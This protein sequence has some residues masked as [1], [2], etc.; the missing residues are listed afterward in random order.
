MGYSRRRANLILAV[1]ALASFAAATSTTALYASPP[2][3][4]QVTGECSVPPIDTWTNQ[5]TWVWQRVCQGQVADFNAAEDYY[6]KPALFSDWAENRILRPGFLETILLTDP[7]RSALTRQG[8]RV[9][10]AWFVEPVDLENA[11]ISHELWL[12]RSRFESDVFLAQMRTS[13]VLSIRGSSIAGFLSANGSQ[14]ENDVF[15]NGGSEFVEVD[16]VGARVRGTLNLFGSSVFG[17]LDL[18]D[19]HVEDLLMHNDAAFNE[20]DLRGAEIDW[21]LFM[22]GSEFAGTLKMH[23][24]RVGEALVMDGEAFFYHVDLRSAK[25]GSWMSMERSEFADFLDMKSIRVGEEPSMGKGAAF[26]A[27]DLSSADIGGEMDMGGSSFEGDVNLARIH[28]GG[29]LHLGNR[30]E[31]ADEVNLAYSNIEG[32]LSLFGGSFESV[33]LTGA[34]VLGEMSLGAPAARWGRASHLN[35]SNT[36]VAVVNDLP[37]AWPDALVLEGFTYA[38]LGGSETE[39]GDDLA[40]RNVDWFKDWLRKEERYSPQPYEQLATVLR[41]AGHG[42]KA[43][44]ILYA[45]RQRS[46]G[47][48][49]GFQRIS[50]T[51]QDL[52]IGYGYRLERTFYWLLFFVALGAVVLTFAGQG[53]APRKL[54]DRLSYSLDLLLPIVRLR[55][56]HYN[57][58]NLQGGARY[59]FF[60]HQ[61]MGYVL[62]LFLAAGVSGLAD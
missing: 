58:V 36:E 35:L 34:K 27:V 9:V 20:V 40:D 51:L 33:D 42:D 60:V 3:D 19:V 28:V 47:N 5:E 12:D 26:G 49:S 37:D 56:A 25:I 13:S 50:L 53:P 31:F 21:F 55:E 62:A 18:N 7:Y 41:D 2:S 54:Q 59:Y 15:M 11:V 45:S 14:M 46:W 4:A 30:A 1:L 8:V 61:L 57:E 52:F 6:P 38:R 10:G 44:D 17:V 39:D 43:S 23:S 16:F 24:I 29:R 48:S 32:N 22:S